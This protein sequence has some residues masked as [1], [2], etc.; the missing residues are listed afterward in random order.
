MG[1]KKIRNWITNNPFFQKNGEFSKSAFI[2]VNTWVVVIIKYVLSGLSFTY[3]KVASVVG[4]ILV[5]AS[6]ITYT[7]KFDSGEAI[8][9]LTIVFGLYFGNKFAP[10]GSDASSKP[11]DL[12]K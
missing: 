9:L 1:I 2:M 4:G 5:P 8:A 12:L 3:T 7:V 11:A 10:A 6:N